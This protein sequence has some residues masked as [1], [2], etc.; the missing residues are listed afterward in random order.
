MYA[1]GQEKCWT[2]QAP[3][4]DCQN[5]N[6]STTGVRFVPI[7]TNLVVPEAKQVLKLLAAPRPLL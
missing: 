1:Q 7:L 2:A 6:S 3:K 5:T 4:K